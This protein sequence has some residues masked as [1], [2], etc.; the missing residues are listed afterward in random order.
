MIEVKKG[1]EPEGLKRLNIIYHLIRQMG[2]MW[3]KDL[4]IE[5]CLL[6]VMATQNFI[7]KVRAE[8]TKQRI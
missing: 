5:I 4:I 3:V 8:Q 1:P 7:R 2:V 6:F